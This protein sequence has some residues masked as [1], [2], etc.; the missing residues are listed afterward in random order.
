MITL[1]SIIN[2]YSSH[3]IFESYEGNCIVETIVIFRN[4]SDIT[5]SSRIRHLRRQ[6]SP[7]LAL[8]SENLQDSELNFDEDDK[9]TLID[10]TVAAG[11]VEINSELK[12][13]INPNEHDTAFFRDSEF[14]FIN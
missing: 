1:T 14:Y 7:T 2:A 10:K 6:R 11:A 5:N 8:L 4:K 9:M 12:D 3:Y 13:F